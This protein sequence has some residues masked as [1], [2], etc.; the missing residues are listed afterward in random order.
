M[1]YI[2]EQYDVEQLGFLWVTL[3]THLQSHNAVLFCCQPLLYSTNFCKE[4]IFLALLLPVVM[5]FCA[6]SSVNFFMK[7]VHLFTLVMVHTSL[8]SDY[9]DR[10]L[11]CVT[12]RKVLT[13]IP[14]TQQ[15][16]HQKDKLLWSQ[17]FLILCVT[18]SWH[19]CSITSIFSDGFFCVPRKA[20]EICMLLNSLMIKFCQF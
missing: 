15:Q 4:Q 8:H 14:I 11:H 7:D 9:Y 6:C 12:L 20:C 19:K 2:L 5:L 3:L 10:P 17:H 16:S 1:R 13:V 18:L